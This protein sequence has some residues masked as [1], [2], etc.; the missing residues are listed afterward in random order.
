M[1]CASG[2]AV[3][4]QFRTAQSSQPARRR[5]VSAEQERLS[6]RGHKL[7]KLQRLQKVQEFSLPDG[8][9]WLR[10]RPTLRKAQVEEEESAVAPENG[11]C[12]NFPEFLWP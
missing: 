5:F 6:A 7:H 8:A 1:A 4:L 2:M 10:R 11:G 9:A 3:G 12:C